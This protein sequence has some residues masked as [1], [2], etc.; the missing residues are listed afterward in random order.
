MIF[1]EVEARNACFSKVKALLKLGVDSTAALDY[2]KMLF[3]DDE[4]EVTFMDFMHAMLTLRGSNTTTVKDIVELRKYVGEESLGG[5]WR[6]SMA[7][8]L[9]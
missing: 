6:G 7:F 1:T 8:A 3:E 4:E 9:P 2:G 5:T